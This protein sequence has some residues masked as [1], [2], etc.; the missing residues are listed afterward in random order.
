MAVPAQLNQARKALE[1]YLEKGILDPQ[2]VREE[3]AHSWQRCRE[4]SL[5]PLISSR[6]ESDPEQDLEKRRYERE[7]LI[8]IARPFLSDLARYVNQT[9]FQ[10]ILTDEDGM[11]LEVAGDPRIVA[12]ARQVHLCAGADW[13]EAFRGTNAI[14][15]AIF[16]RV[17]VQIHAWEHFR[18]ENQFLTCSASPIFDPTGNI[19]GAI[20]ISGDY[21]EANPHT[22]GMVVSTTRAIENQL[23]LEAAM[24]RLTLASHYSSAIVRGITDGLIAIDTNGIVTEMNAR[25]GEIF[26]L[27]P[28][29]VKGLPISQ[30]CS[31]KA[32]LLQVIKSGKEYKN[33]EISLMPSGPRI[34]SSASLL[35]DEHG[36]VLGAVAFFRELPGSPGVRRSTVFFSHHYQFNDIVG[37]SL[38]MQ[39]AK[40]WASLA[41]TCSSTVLI[42]GESGTGKEIFA[43][44]IHHASAR[45]RGPF[46][47]INCAA[48]P[49][50]LIES[51]LFGYCDGSF[52]GAKKGGQAGKFEMA[53]GGTIFLDEVGEMS[54]SMQAKLLRVLQE[55]TLTRVGSSTEINVDIRVIAATHCDLSKDVEAGRFRE[56]LYYRLAVLELRIPPLRERIEDIPALARTLVAKIVARLERPPVTLL[57]DSF[58]KLQSYPWPGNVREM[59]NV[60]ERALIRSRGSAE[61]ASQFIDLPE[62]GTRPLPVREPA[63]RSPEPAHDHRSLREHE[64]Q[65]IMDALNACHGNI[66]RTA[67]QLGIARNTLYRKM[68][69]YDLV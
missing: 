12:R 46:L 63:M 14:G 25:G 13:S 53:S 30:I 50:A 38:P 60:L 67:A 47:A 54:L 29:S 57:P 4:L 24:T 18:E 43:N 34:E 2:L 15:T 9:N 49:E 23:R 26:G 6:D 32:P 19:A 33:Q 62:K 16:E 20:D 1:L 55:R 22:L 40:D 58:E 39:K 66:K 64:K 3:V 51:E 45:S 41:A 8:H 36:I 69:D 5:N 21:R 27:N 44:A 35:R 59:E 17:P 10:V 37:E 28:D 42:L 65:A 56:D 68:Q 48:M 7:H 52:T 31:C 11:L 61:L